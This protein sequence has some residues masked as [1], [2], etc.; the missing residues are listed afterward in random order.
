M[1]LGFSYIHTWEKTHMEPED[2]PLEDRF[3]ST[4]QWFSGSMSFFLGNIADCCL[5]FFLER[6]FFFRLACQKQLTTGE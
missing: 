4:T 1:Q 6:L 2:E 3:S 5:F